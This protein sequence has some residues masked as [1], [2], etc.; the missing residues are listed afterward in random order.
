MT[1]WHAGMARIERATTVPVQVLA[2]RRG[3]AYRDLG[4]FQVVMAS[5]RYGTDAQV[6]LDW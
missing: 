4:W 1:S 5:D 6:N 2:A 3:E